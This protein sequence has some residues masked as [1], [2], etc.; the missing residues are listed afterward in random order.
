MDDPNSS[1]TCSVGGEWGGEALSFLDEAD[2]S[3]LDKHLGPGLKIQREG[4]GGGCGWHP[5]KPSA[6]ELI[7]LDYSMLGSR[8]GKGRKDAARVYITFEGYVRPRV[9]LTC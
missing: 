5:G 7:N 6:S 9:H 8:G 1:E 4:R 3:S 2:N